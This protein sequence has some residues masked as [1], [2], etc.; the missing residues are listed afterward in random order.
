MFSY[1]FSLI[2]CLIDRSVKICDSWNSFHNDIKSIKSNLI[3]NGYSPFL[4]G[5]IIQNYLNQKFCSNKN[6]LKDTSDVY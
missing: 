1:K 5:K 3:K 4:I 6:Q 2:K